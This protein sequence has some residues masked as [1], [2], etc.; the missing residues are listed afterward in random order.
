[1]Q[2]GNISMTASTPQRHRR[3]IGDSTGFTI[4]ELCLV[5]GVLALLVAMAMPYYQDHLTQ[6]KHAV[7]RANLHLLK[8]SLMEYKSDRGYYPEHLTDLAPQYLLEIPIDPEPDAPPNWGYQRPAPDL[9]QLSGKY[10]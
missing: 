1:M 3:T 6:S 5:V 7:M 9:Y 2:P 4:V 8:K 10:Q